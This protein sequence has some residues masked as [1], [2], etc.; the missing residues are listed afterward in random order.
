LSK[1]AK[2]DST[3]PRNADHLQKYK[4][5]KGQ[6]SP[7]PGVP[8]V[9]ADHLQKY[10]WKKGGPSPNPGGGP[11]KFTTL[12]T[13]AIR[14][15][16][17]ELSPEDKKTYAA[18]IGSEMV[19][20]AARE[21]KEKGLTGQVLTFYRDVR[22]GTEGKPIQKVVIDDNATTDPKERIKQLLDAARQRRDF[23]AGTFS[24]D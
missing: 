21:I 7:N 13:D 18:V 23:A 9:L 24:A 1:K 4:W 15:Q 10:K 14:D 6:A 2:A 3:K 5:K 22:D 8:G 11:K 20:A 19:K 12:L 16:L 17:G